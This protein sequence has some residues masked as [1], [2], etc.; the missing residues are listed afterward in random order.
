MNMALAEVLNGNLTTGFEFLAQKVLTGPPEGIYDPVFIRAAAAARGSEIRDLVSKL[1]GKFGKDFSSRRFEA[2]IREAKAELTSALPSKLI[3]SDTGAPKPILANAVTFLAASPVK[4]AFDA[5]A[6]SIVHQTA[7]PWGTDGHWSDKDDLE[8]ANY[9]QHAGITVKTDTAH[10]AVLCLA[11]RNSFHPVRDWLTSLK[12]DGNPRVEYLASVYFGCNEGT[13]ESG[14]ST[15]WMVSA[16][17]RI[18]RPG[19]Q[20]KYMIVLEGPQEQGKSK[21]LRAL[22]NGHLEGE[23]GIQWFRDTLPDID[24]KDI[25]LYMQGVWIIEIA[26][27]SAIRGKQW[28]RTK[29]FISTQRDTFRVPYGRNMQDYSR[30]CIFAASTN[31]DQ[32]GG[33]PTGLVRFWP[34]RV[35]K[36]NI[37]LILRDREQLW[38]EALV[39]FDEGYQGRL[40]G[41]AE[42]IARLEQSARQPEDLWHDRVIQAVAELTQFDD[43]V[44]VPLIIEKMKVPDSQQERVKWQVG[45]ILRSEG[46]QRVQ[47]RTGKGTG[48]TW[49]FVKG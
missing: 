32:W 6:C 48:P 31:E 45:S 38:A 9:L 26:E 27:L 29:S 20:A 39:K 12:W 18:M 8:V 13:Y 7:S 47:R 17:S 22:A 1:K 2:D 16:V 24:H 4:V 28:E 3:L 41:D 46:W 5:F 15:A 21:G 11:H 40:V 10:E 42:Q 35:G 33:D 14:V 36:I 30:Q 44:S 37:P 23:G 49:G 19:C 34:L 25:G 43:W